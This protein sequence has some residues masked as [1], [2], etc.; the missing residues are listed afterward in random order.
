MVV[1]GKI[2]KGEY[3]DSVS[4]MIVG[5]KIAGLKGV[6]DA[7]VVMGT[8]ENKSILENSGLLL[9]E[10]LKA[11]DTDLLIA[12]KGKD[13]GTVDKVHAAVQSHLEEVKKRPEGEAEFRPRS[14]EGALEIVP[15]AN[16]ALISVAGRYAGGEA[17]QALDKGL[18][19]MLFSDNVPL[20]TEIELKKR[21]K[22][23][24]LLVMGPDCGTAIINGA[25]LAFANVV[26]RGCVGVVGAAG[27]GTQEVTCIV[28]NEGAGISQAIGT[29]GRDVKKD[30][31]GI[32]FIEALKALAKDKETKVI[33][34]VSKPPHESVLRKIGR[35]IK[36]IKKPVVAVLL[37]ADPRAVARYGAYGAATLEEAALL[38]ANLAV[39][40][41]K[42]AVEETA[43]RLR[44]RHEEDALNV[45]AVAV[46]KLSKRQRWVR[47]LFSGGTFVAEAQVLLQGELGEIHSNAPLGDAKKLENS[48]R[49]VGHSVVDL[50][51]D[52][53]TVGR[54]HPMIDFT[55]RNNRILAEAKDPETAVILLD[56]VLGHGSNLDP[57]GELVPVVEKASK[58]VAIVCSVTGTDADPQGKTRVE[59]ALMEAGALVMASNAM[60]CRVACEVARRQK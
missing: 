1:K 15:D 41:K 37:G 19:V 40:D 14:L 4:L 10:F 43:R 9:R 47:G 55:L 2:K 44:A 12:V 16:L 50:G 60:A 20:E 36:K 39:M 31:G 34:L 38:S 6:I 23:K 46:N 35:E 57:A 3:F 13:A 51:E 24:G 17:M 22:E 42:H 29:G 54:P 52:E 30:V 49:S 59:R 7:A 8:K 11:G 32:M 27:T 33:L 56:V 26:S 48:L 53:F 21:G 28:S 58:T 18:H 45:A 5:K 25:P